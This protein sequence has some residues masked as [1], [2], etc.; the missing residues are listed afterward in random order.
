MHDAW[1]H[2][3]QHAEPHAT[4]LPTWP[5]YDSDQRATMILDT[6]CHVVDDPNAAERRVWDGRT[7]PESPWWPLLSRL[8]AQV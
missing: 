1:T 8:D 3:I 7:L 4:T 2:F 5:R 6:P